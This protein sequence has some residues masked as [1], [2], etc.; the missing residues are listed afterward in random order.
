M[1]ADRCALGYLG[2]DGFFIGLLI[3]RAPQNGPSSFRVE[4][5]GQNRW[6]SSSSVGMWAGRLPACPHVHGAGLA[7]DCHERRC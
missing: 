2:R 7:R 4:P 5:N 6:P 3:C 1:E